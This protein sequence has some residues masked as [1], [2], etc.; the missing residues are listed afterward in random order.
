MRIPVSSGLSLDSGT[1]DGSLGL[2]ASRAEG[3]PHPRDVSG[4]L[5]LASRAICGVTSL[6]LPLGP[7]F[8]GQ[9]E[10]LVPGPSFPSCRTTA[11]L[12]SPGAGAGG[13]AEALWPQRAVAGPREGSRAP[14]G[15]PV[16]TV[17]LRPL[18]AQDR[19]TALRSPRPVFLDARPAATLVPAAPRGNC[20]RQGPWADISS[21]L[22]APAEPSPSPRVLV[23]VAARPALSG[24]VSSPDR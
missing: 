19:T 23:A 18:R 9:R 13:A 20:V 4:H 10:G 8:G 15:L 7:V 5:R 21:A 17:P 14:C 6:G 22:D 1:V 12:L 3:S 24:S 16:L 11:G 2:R